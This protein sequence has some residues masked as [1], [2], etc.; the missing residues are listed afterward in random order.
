MVDRKGMPAASNSRGAALLIA[1]CATLADDRAPAA[2]RLYQLIGP[3]L[4]R[5]LVGA[6]AGDHRMF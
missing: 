6:L 4:T 2:E 1:H 5:L 3:D